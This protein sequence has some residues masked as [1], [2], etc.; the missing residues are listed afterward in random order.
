MNT[1]TEMINK[2]L[3]NPG[4]AMVRRNKTNFIAVPM[5][6][7]D[8]TVTYMSIKV[9]ELLA[10][11]TKT[12][13]AFDFEAAKAEY[14]EWKTEKDRPKEKKA[15]PAKVDPEKAAEKAARQEAVLTWLIN[16]P[17]KHSSTEIYEALA[18]V[19]AGKLIM[20]VGSDC[21]AMVEDGRIKCHREKAK[22]FFFFGDDEETEE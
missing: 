3:E 6:N 16:N 15:R 4:S 8:G 2:I 17:G 18:D 21:K 22:N 1:T 12:N 13:P 19:Y 10:Q 7:E 9:G 5:E 20:A 14:D 11:D